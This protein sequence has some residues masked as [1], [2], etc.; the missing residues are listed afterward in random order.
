MSILTVGNFTNNRSAR[1]AALVLLIIGAQV[2]VTARAASLPT[3]NSPEQKSGDDKSAQ[4]AVDAPR[5]N[6]Q[7]MPDAIT[8]EQNRMAPGTAA[9]LRAEGYKLEEID[10]QGDAETI[11]VDLKTGRSFGAA[12]PRN[13]EAKAVGY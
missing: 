1:W 12:D 7:W 3:Q 5:I 6:E 9:G 10:R 8:C 4:Q 11:V 13:P 2:L